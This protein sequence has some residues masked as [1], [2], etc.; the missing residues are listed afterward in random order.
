MKFICYV[1]PE[2]QLIG[3]FH[4]SDKM[5][6]V[7]NPDGMDWGGKEATW[8]GIAW[9]PIGNKVF[10][11]TDDLQPRSSDFEV[12]LTVPWG[13]VTL[14]ASRISVELVTEE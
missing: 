10:V 3:G 12:T 8:D 9:T 11:E 14:K 5:K 7:S 13:Q 6:S 4:R 2:D 1:N